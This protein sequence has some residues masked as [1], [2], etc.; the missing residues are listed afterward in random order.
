MNIVLI[1]MPGCG[2]SSVGKRLAGL[3]NMKFVDTDTLIE[4]KTGKNLQRIIDEVGNAEFLRIEAEAIASLECENCVIA[5]GGSAVLTVEGEKALGRLGVLVYLRHSCE[6]IESRVK[7]LSTRGVAM[8]VGQTFRDVY[9][10]RVGIYER[11]AGIIV[12]C[13]KLSIYET[14][15]LIIEKIGT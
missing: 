12:D 2:K 13:E 3:R 1:G 15:K 7:N 8:D 14:A 9:N 4:K 10:Y 5:S 11:A 6:E